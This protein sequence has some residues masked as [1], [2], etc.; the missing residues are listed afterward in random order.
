MR[1][2]AASPDIDREKDRKEWKEWKD[3]SETCDPSI[4]FIPLH[5]FPA[6]VGA[7]GETES[8]HATSPGSSVVKDEW[9]WKD[10]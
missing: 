4:P 1:D 5:P 3:R 9:A 2:R 7:R 8:D 6:V 10:Q